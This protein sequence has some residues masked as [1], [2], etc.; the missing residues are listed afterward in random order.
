MTVEIYVNTLTL[1]QKALP[2]LRQGLMEKVLQKSEKFQNNILQIIT[3]IEDGTTSEVILHNW[4]QFI[5]GKSSNGGSYY[6]GTHYYYEPESNM[7]LKQYETSSDMEL[8]PVCGMFGNHEEYNEETG[9]FSG[10]ACREPEYY[11]TS[12]IIRIIVKFMLKHDDDMNYC[13]VTK[14]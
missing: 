9:E 8:C 11:Y 6:F 3:E 10:Y 12:S 5:E 4:S 7:W 14:K 13:I 2:Y 1:V